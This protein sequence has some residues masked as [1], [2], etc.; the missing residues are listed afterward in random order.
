MSQWANG[1][2]G[3]VGGYDREYPATVASCL[4]D[5]GYQTRAVGKMHVY[6][7]RK[8]WG[9]QHVV[10]DE[11]SRRESAGF[12]SDYH[13]YFEDHKDGPYGYRDHGL[14]WN[15]WMSR[16][17]HL[18]EHLHPT[19][20]TSMEGRRF[21]NHR[22]PTKPFFLFLSFARPHSPYDPPQS[23]FDMYDG[24]EDLPEAAV[25]DWAGLYDSPAQPDNV[26]AWRSARSAV[27][28]RRARAGYYGSVTFIDHQ[29]GM[30]LYELQAVGEAANTM[31]VFCSDH[32]DMLGDHHLW[33]KTYAYEGSA[34]VPFIVRPPAT[35]K[36][37][38]HQ[39]VDQ[40]VELRDI[41]PTLLE[42]AGAPIPASVDGRS[43]LPLLRGETAGWREYLHGEA[44][45][46][47]QPAAGEPLCHR[48]A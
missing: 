5:A 11:S 31:I 24:R 37:P 35:M 4:T 28:T 29:I 34:R 16:P 13:Q 17:S 32:G 43:V 23:Y 42:A 40:V 15:S 19:W 3:Y 44:L 39:V 9:F 27:E 36:L 38:G 26:N 8:L 2:L 48:W 25:G 45:G 22:D 20:W 33:R 41:M 30:L 47:L 10:L 21:L 18:P 46:L 6:P 1:Q 14:D 7:Q 12:V